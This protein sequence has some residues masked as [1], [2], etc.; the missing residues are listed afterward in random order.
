[1]RIVVRMWIAASILLMLVSAPVSAQ[2]LPTLPKVEAPTPKA[3]KAAKK[4]YGKA[5]VLFEKGQLGRAAK[6]ARLAYS[7]VPSFFTSMALTDILADIGL[8]KEAFSQALIT[9]ELAT[10]S[11]RGQANIV[12]IKAGPQMVPQHAAVRIVVP[13]TAT[14]SVGN[15][16]FKGSRSIGLTPGQHVVTVSAPGKE[17]KTV[18]V[19][20]R[21]STTDIVNIS[22]DKAK[23]KLPDPPALKCT[24]PT[25]AKGGKCVQPDV[26]ST[27]DAEPWEPSAGPWVMIG[28]GGAMVVAGGVLLALTQGELDSAGEFVSP[29]AGMSEAD[30]QT[31]YNGHVDTAKTYYYGGFIVGGVGL[32]AV[33][34]GAVWKVLDSPPSQDS[35][36]GL[37]LQ[38]VGPWTGPNRAGL[39][40]RGSF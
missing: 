36:V 21:L 15:V 6:Q 13:P 23:V 19:T 11:Q 27:S 25:V 28:V 5:Q 29:V 33:V 2:E 38:D 26:P 1:M 39:L 32:A 30:R 40:L 16:R 37:Q 22:L 10:P 9:S 14:V 31:N 24:P 3:K 18:K 8:W 7:L 12:L 20:A 17:A 4:A 35:E 34:A